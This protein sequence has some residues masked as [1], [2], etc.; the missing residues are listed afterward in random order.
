[1]SKTK[2]FLGLRGENG[3]IGYLSESLSIPEFFELVRPKSE[4]K[5][6]LVD[7]SPVIEALHAKHDKIAEQSIREKYNAVFN[8]WQESKTYSKLEIK[9]PKFESLSQ[10]SNELI[11]SLQFRINESKRGY[12]HR[13]TTDQEKN[14]TTIKNIENDCNVYI[15]VLLCFIHAKASLEIE[16]FKKD[17]VLGRYCDFLK[18]VISDLYNRVVEFSTWNDRFELDD[19]SLLYHIAFNNNEELNH[20]TKLLPHFDT[21]QDLRLQ[22]MIASRSEPMYSHRNEPI[23]R[24][25]IEYRSPDNYELEAAKILRNLLHKINSISELITKLREGNV[26]WNPSEDGAEELKQLLSE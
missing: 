3:Q 26:D 11:T 19:S 4:T 14:T 8:Y 24:I 18:E 2:L 5:Y 22:R 21:S 25:E 10:L 6:D 20:Y 9:L 16:S 12:S 15:D 17:V 7:F 23:T 13:R 1:M